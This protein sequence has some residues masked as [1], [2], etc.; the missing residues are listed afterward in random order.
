MLK[1]LVIPLLLNLIFPGLPDRQ[2]YE[3]RLKEAKELYESSMYFPA[4]EKFN[5]LKNDGYE[6]TLLQKS[7]ISAYIVY[8]TIYLN[9]PNIDNAVSEFNL[10][11]PFSEHSD[12][13][14][15]LYAFYYYDKG[16]YEKALTIYKSMKNPVLSKED[17]LDFIYNRAFCYLR[18]SDYGMAQSGFEKI[19]SL[20]QNKYTNSA[21]YHLGYIYYIYKDFSKAISYF[22]QLS[23]DNLYSLNSRYFLLESQFMLKNHSY[24]LEYGPEL[25]KQIDGDLKNKTARIISESSLVAGKKKQAKAYLDIYTR[26]GHELTRKDNYFAGLVSYSLGAYYSAIDAFRKI[27]SV[28]DT[29]TQSAF[30]HL[31]N[32]YLK[33]KNKHKAIEVFKRASEKDYNPD[34]REEAYFQYAKLSFDVKGDIN[35][36]NEYLAAYPESSRSDIIYNYIASSCL[37]KKD[38]KNAVDALSKIQKPDPGM[39]LNLQKAAYF[40]GMEQ[41][42]LGSYKSA[43][44]SFSLSVKNGTNNKR[45]LDLA[46]YWLAETCYRLADYDASI[47]ILEELTG[48]SEF[49]KTAEYPAS[50][51]NMGYAY[52]GKRDYEKSGEWFE[53]YLSLEKKNTGMTLEAR[54]R[55]ADSYFMRGMYD[56]SAELY[57]YVAKYDSSKDRIYPSFYAAKSYG[58][59]SDY[60]KKISILEKILED[61]YE[62]ALYQQAK[63]ELAQ[64]YMDVQNVSKAIRS[65]ENILSCETDSLLYS[66][67]YLGLGLAYSSMDNNDEAFSYYDKVVK[68]YRY[69]PEFDDA[70]AGI[71]MIYNQWYKPQEYLDYL[72]ELGMEDIKTASEKEEMFFNACEQAFLSGDNMLAV[73]K[74]DEFLERYPEGV[75]MPHV[76]YYKGE[77]LMAMG[78]NESAAEQFK[79]VMEKGEGSFKELSALYYGDISYKLENY[80]E[81]V[82]G[83]KVLSEIARLDNNKF[84][85]VV[86]LMRSY[87]RNADYFD[88]IKSAEAIMNSTGD[89]DENL[90]EEALYISAKSYS[91]SGNRPKSLELYE[92]LARNAMS[93]YGAEA[94]YLIISDYYDSGE[95]EK[96]EECVYAFSDTSTPQ[97]YWLAK[98]FIILG[99]SFVERGNVEQAI[100][101]YTSIKDEYTPRDNKD[102]VLSQVDMRL[103]RM[104]ETGLG[105]IK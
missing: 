40:R 46:K 87:Y 84:S 93:D 60:G 45:L 101:T 11:Y 54:K 24:V 53:Q 30:Y 52:Y 15:F 51:Y 42:S 72:A 56:K 2:S 97:L 16:E 34:I 37:L 75:K 67:A 98:S 7:E 9:R 4:Y 48:D 39:V 35:V 85:A 86:G 90:R 6:L 25:F 76:Y 59:L 50:I 73:K 91:M 71:E 89:V 23:D 65:Y 33:I 28:D 95:F 66:R 88:A 13:I 81:A 92:I 64:A 29:L 22:E 77:A 62:S 8:C 14:N 1:L 31:G 61:N 80:Q 103:K 26:S 78:K 38:Y 83:Y 41:F 18:V 105:I 10:E 44:E 57:S 79:V 70:L 32:T 55:L 5:S 68:N 36:F 47:D 82:Y 94:R 104:E 102:D 21:K 49:R 100:A 43:Q 96:V 17:R 58:L 27:V 19:L 12:K 69:T 3:A 63:L 99:D 20:G 74:A